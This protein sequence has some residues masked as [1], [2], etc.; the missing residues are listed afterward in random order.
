MAN[1]HFYIDLNWDAEFDLL[2]DDTGL[3]VTL[4]V[5][6]YECILPNSKMDELVSKYAE[7]KALAYWNEH[8][9]QSNG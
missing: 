4:T 2:V 3:E 8:G 6:G 1:K 9:D 5:E 7:A